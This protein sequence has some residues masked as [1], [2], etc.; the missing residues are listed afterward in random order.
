MVAV[1]II[2]QMKSVSRHGGFQV[3]SGIG[4]LVL[5]KLHNN[6]NFLGDM[7]G[8]D[9]INTYYCLTGVWFDL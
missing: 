3:R 8:Q 5:N 6:N 4:V 1:A 9:S 2:A 7:R